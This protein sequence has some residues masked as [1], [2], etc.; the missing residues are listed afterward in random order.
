M[1][2]RYLEFVRREATERHRSGMGPFEAALDIDLGHEA[3]AGPELFTR[4]QKYRA[5]R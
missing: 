4:M 5:Q 2:R 3:A 1:V